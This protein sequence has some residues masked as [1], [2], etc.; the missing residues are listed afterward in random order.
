[1]LWF[2]CSWPKIAGPGEASFHRE[3][4]QCCSGLDR[5][6]LRKAKKS[7]RSVV[8]AIATA[9]VVTVDVTVCC[10]VITVVVIFFFVMLMT[11]NIP[12]V[13]VTTNLFTCL[14][15]HAAI[16]F[17]VPCTLMFVCSSFVRAHNPASLVGFFITKKCKKMLSVFWSPTPLSLSLSPFL[18]LLSVSLCLYMSLL[19]ILFSENHSQAYQHEQQRG[20]QHHNR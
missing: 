7:L 9:A 5:T 10:I 20:R 13:E 6:H 12:C 8:A 11:S 2:F 19:L 15:K 17:S 4:R 14:T 16:T 3:L 18:S 1:M